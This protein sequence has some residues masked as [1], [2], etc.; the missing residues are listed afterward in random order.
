MDKDPDSQHTHTVTGTRYNTRRNGSSTIVEETQDF[1]DALE[2]MKYLEQHLLL[3]PAGEPALH[4]SLST[5][6]YQISALPNASKPI[7]NAI[8]AVALLLDKLEVTHIYTA[9]K[10]AVDIQINE[11]ATDIHKLVED[12][13]DKLNDATTDIHKLVK[14][15]SDKLNDKLN[16]QF[17][18]VKAKIASLVLPTQTTV[19]NQPAHSY[20]AALINPPPH[21][22]PKLTA[23]KGIKACQFAISGIK[24]SSISHLNLSQIKALIN[25]K[26]LELDLPGGK[27]CSLINTHSN[28]IILE[29][30]DDTTTKWLSVEN[31]QKKLCKKIDPTIKFYAREY[32]IIAFNVPIDM[33]PK[34]Q[35]TY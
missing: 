11:A 22:N 8:H 3:C 29:A 20:A 10:E 33:D 19:I 25:N 7:V 2:G 14:D 28:S 12:T 24:I 17:K 16:D 31:N 4:Q 32:K 34:S 13:S 9:V 6:L 23:C 15:T 26:L 5:C 1:R 35:T 18:L 21:A 27:I 30:E